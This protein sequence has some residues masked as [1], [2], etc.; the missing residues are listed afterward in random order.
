M[1]TLLKSARHA[2]RGIRDALHQERNFQIQIIMAILVCATATFL[3]FSWIEWLFVIIA[4][5]MVL[6]A[7]LMNTVVE[8]LLD[9]LVPHQHETV[10]MLKDIMAGMVL[11]QSLGALVIGIIVVLHHIYAS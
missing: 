8:H 9:L 11:I 10:R 1:K 6:A 3:E 4:I 5:V 7:E 2:A